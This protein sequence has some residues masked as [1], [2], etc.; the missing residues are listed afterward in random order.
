[1]AQKRLPMRK[2][3][4]I[5]EYHFGRGLSARSIA[6]NCGVSR[7]AVSQTL[8]RFAESGLDWR[9]AAGLD[10]PALEKAL[11]PPR[12]ALPARGDVDWEGVEKALAG[13]GVTLKLLWEEWRGSHPD[14]MSYVTWCRRF[15]AWRP[16]PAVTMR[17]NRRPGE[18]LFV[19]YAG[20][21]GSGAH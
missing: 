11:Y 17:Q 16:G 6:A 3:K 15:R 5:L 20:M 13:R 10:E 14:G 8:K 1:M 9:A 18:R 7:R 2:V 19:D 4:K 12:P 21:T